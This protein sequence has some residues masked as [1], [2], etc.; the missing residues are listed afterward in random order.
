MELFLLKMFLFKGTQEKIH[1]QI[2]QSKYYYR[3]WCFRKGSD[4]LK[5]NI[6]YIQCIQTYS[7]FHFVHNNLENLFFTKYT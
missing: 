2:L 5:Q 1:L 4:F 3:I 6:L 7:T